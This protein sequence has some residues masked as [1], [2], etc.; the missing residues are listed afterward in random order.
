M[1]PK[2]SPTSVCMRFIASFLLFFLVSV[3]TTDS[4]D[5]S[6]LQGRDGSKDEN[7]CTFRKET[8]VS[9]PLVR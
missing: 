3:Q 2:S 5:G 9:S 6:T 8:D 7:E 4:S 1:C